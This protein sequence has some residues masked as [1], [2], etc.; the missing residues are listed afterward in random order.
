MTGLPRRA[1]PPLPREY[2]S[3]RVIR[4]TTL[5]PCMAVPVFS[6]AMKRSC[7]PG[8]LLREKSVAGLMHVQ[9][10]GDEIRFR[11]Q[12]VTIFPDAGDLSFLFKIAQHAAQLISLCCAV[13]ERVCDFDFVERPIFRVTNEPDN[14]CAQISFYFGSH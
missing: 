11:R 10:A 5:S 8:F 14:L 4:A 12:D 13:T 3:S 7:S 9:R 1:R 6:A 2:C